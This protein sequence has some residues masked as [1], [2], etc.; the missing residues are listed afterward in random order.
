[1]P[2]RPADLGTDHLPV[3][4]RTPGTVSAVEPLL[5]LCRHGKLYEVEAWIDEGKPIQYPP[6]DDRKLQRRPTALQIAIQR[7]FHSLVGLLLANG[8]DPNGDYYECL[9]PAV[10]NKE[11]E[12]VDLLLRFGAD[13]HVVDFCRVLEACD[14]ELMDRFIAAGVDPCHKNA[15]ARAVSSGRRPIFG[16]IKQY[17]DRFPGMQRQ[18]DIALREATTGEQVRAVAMLL[19]VGADPHA[20]TPA[21][22]YNDDAEALHKSAF[23]EAIWSEKPEILQM[24]LKKPIP[25]GKRQSL[26][27][28]VS[29]RSRPDLVRRLV[30]EGVD[31]N[32]ANE[33]GYPALYG[34]VH[35]L[36]WRFGSRSGVEIARGFEALELI[37]AAGAKWKLSERQLKSLRRDLADGESRVV[38]R[39][40]DELHRFDAISVE[41]LKELART[42]AVRRVLNGVSK[43]RRDYLGY[44]LPRSASPVPTQGGYWKR[45]WSQ[46]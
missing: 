30:E 37:L 41:D 14:R 39:L 8:Y 19:W 25:P 46:R 31:V 40:L 27:S 26:L 4:H 32:A 12:M 9:S 22:P 16:F 24:F 28:T 38:V 15:L 6:P 13:P 34:F 21:T 18:I 10:D 3:T 36:L 20:E 7:G 11:R 29:Y 33:E 17:R 44:S 45:H 42:P 23:E 43:P 35:A 5:A 2:R 1:M